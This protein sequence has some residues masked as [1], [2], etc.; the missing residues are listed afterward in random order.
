MIE[1][2][3]LQVLVE[4]LPF[5]LPVVLIQLG[6][7]VFA[8][9]DLA[10]RPATRGPRWVWALMLIISIGGFPTGLIISAVYLFWGRNVEVG[11]D[12]Y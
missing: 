1:R 5:I 12:T 11:N 7:I 2:D 3:A 4:L 9:I 8:L 10:R 6:I